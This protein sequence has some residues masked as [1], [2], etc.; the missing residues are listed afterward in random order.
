LETKE[1]VAMKRIRMERDGVDETTI[2]EI[3]LL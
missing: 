3:S 1:I 2:R